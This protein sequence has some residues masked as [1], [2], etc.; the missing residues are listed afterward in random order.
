MVPSVAFEI[1]AATAVTK[2]GTLFMLKSL[3]APLTALMLSSV[4][5]VPAATVAYVATAD[6]AAAKS[7]RA[8]G[9][10][11]RGGGKSSSSNSKASGSKGKSGTKSA[12][13]GG[14]SQ[15]RGQGG[16]AGFFDKLTGKDKAAASKTNTKSHGGAAKVAA[17]RIE[18]P[19]N[20]DLMH[21]SN[22][23][24]MNGPMNASINAVMAHIK[25]GNTNG[26]MGAF[27][28]LAVAGANADGAQDLATLQRE[29]KKS[30]YET[31]EDYFEARQGEEPIE[32]IKSI[33]DA[34]TAS[35]SSTEEQTDLAKALTDAGYT[36]DDPL[37]DYQK[38]KE[39]TPPA[40]P[41]AEL[42]AAIVALGGTVVDPEDDFSAYTKPTVTDEELAGAEGDLQAQ[43]DAELAM[44]EHWNKNP[45]TDPEAISE[46]ERA[47][48][49]KLYDRLEPFA[50][51][52]GELLPEREVIEE[53]LGEG[54]EATGCEAEAAECLVEEE[55]A[56]AE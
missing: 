41:I 17:A 55:I 18:E 26:P 48:L 45:D 30:N 36:G 34:L 12:S 52:I 11:G 13:G 5:M 20:K 35:G 22:L 31:L 21:P 56:A 29:I 16:L 15:S 50:E 37:F 24:K 9:G 14:S 51:E 19:T 43:F 28:A 44:L 40:E 6:I 3:K 54:G 49:N 10:G 23:G 27:A 33:E 32:P 4:A 38:D 8:G 39:G 46:E 42:D 53:D 7:D 47:I 1:R 2:Q 25:N